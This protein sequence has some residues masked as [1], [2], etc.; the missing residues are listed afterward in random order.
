MV[1]VQVVLGKRVD[2]TTIHIQSQSNMIAPLHPFVSPGRKFPH[3]GLGKKMAS[4]EALNWLV[5]WLDTSSNNK[6][7][8]CTSIERRLMEATIKGRMVE[9]PSMIWLTM[10]T[11]RGHISS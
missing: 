2:W 11:R 7:I 9:T 10:T 8:D 6:I 3:G 5:V 4:K 1:Y